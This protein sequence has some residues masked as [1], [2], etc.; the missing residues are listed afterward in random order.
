MTIAETVRALG[1][2]AE[3]A[4]ADKKFVIE[5]YPHAILFTFDILGVF[6]FEVHAH[7][8]FYKAPMSL[9][10][11]SPLEEEAWALA[12]QHIERQLTK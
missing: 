9:L 8:Q 7:G 4:G 11:T 10:G 1:V 6:W 3:S 2:V 5:R 12:R